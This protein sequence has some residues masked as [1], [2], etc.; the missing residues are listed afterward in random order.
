MEMC[1]NNKFELIAEILTVVEER[2]V[3]MDLSVA[4]ITRAI[5]MMMSVLNR[6][7]RRSK[8]DADG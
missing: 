2:A 7:M 6:R 4:Y 3:I 8:F 5:D 1:F